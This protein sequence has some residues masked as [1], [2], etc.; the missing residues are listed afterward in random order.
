MQE[1]RDGELLVTD[2]SVLINFL[3]I[4]RLDILC[5][6]PADTLVTHHMAGEISDFYPDQRIIFENALREG[7]FRVVGPLSEEENAVIMELLAGGR[8][9]IGEC[10]AIAYSINRNCKLAMDDRRANLAAQSL[11][12]DLTLLR[13]QDLMVHA[14]QRGELTLDDADQ[15]KEN[16]EMHHQFCLRF[17]SFADLF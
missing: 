14:I 13:T 10:S 15:I 8:L 1:A 4:D 16:W 6:Y 3:R 17:E 12:P 9:G 5:G 11:S 2:A 7:L